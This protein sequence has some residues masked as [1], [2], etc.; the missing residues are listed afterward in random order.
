MK[1]VTIAISLGAI[2]LASIL[3]GCGW[4]YSGTAKQLYA[5]AQN[6]DSDAM[7]SLGVDC[8]S[9]KDGAP[10]DTKE[11][12]KWIEKSAKA[13]NADAAWHYGM[14]L[15]CGSYGVPR[16]EGMFQFWMKKSTRLGGLVQSMH[17]T[18]LRCL[19]YAQS[20]DGVSPS[21]AKDISYGEDVPGAVEQAFNFYRCN[22]SKLSD[23]DKS[24]TVI[25][26]V[27]GEKFDGT[28]FILADGSIK[29][30]P[31]RP[32]FGAKVRGLVLPVRETQ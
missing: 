13:G 7:L 12:V 24:R 29:G 25:V 19:V 22:V 11:G 9:G 3:V 8:L 4:R 27:Y 18:G 5:M 14:I 15:F 28:I 20:N 23:L 6:G 26:A 21:E 17:E 30:A 32:D 2:A 16:D 31:G 10:R 1:Q